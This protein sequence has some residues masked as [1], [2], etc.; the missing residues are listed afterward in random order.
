MTEQA[1]T[2]SA[3][4]AWANDW[5]AIDWKVIYTQVSRLQMRI[6]KAVRII[7]QSGR[8]G[9]LAQVLEPS[10]G[11]LSRWVLRGAGDRKAP[12]LLG[13]LQGDRCGTGK[14]CGW[15]SDRPFIVRRRARIK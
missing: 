5:K 12:R 14:I 11:K 8:F 3:P 2:V 13:K 10:D 1:A 15:S 6:A 7:G 9:R 4:P